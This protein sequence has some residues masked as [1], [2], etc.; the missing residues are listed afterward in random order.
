MRT[1][2]AKAKSRRLQNYV[3]GVFLHLGNRLAHPPLQSGDVQPR[4][5]GGAGV[6]IVLSPTA[7][8]MFPFAVEC[9]QVEKLNV[10]EAFTKNY[11]RYENGNTYPILVHSKNRSRVLVTLTFRDFL[12][13]VYGEHRRSLSGCNT[14]RIAEVCEKMLTVRE[15]WEQIEAL[16]PKVPDTAYA[17][18]PMEAPQ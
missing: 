16:I 3:A 1:S 11:D 17:P 7:F 9:K 5:M 14:A 12:L 18:D 2:S 10:Y 4:Q 6:D 8:K 13:L 15:S